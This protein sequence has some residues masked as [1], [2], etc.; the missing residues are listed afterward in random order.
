MN[1][2]EKKLKTTRERFLRYVAFDTTSDGGSRTVPSTPGQTAFGKELCREITE[3]GIEDVRMDEK[4]YIYGSL[5]AN[6]EK[7]VPVIGFLAHLDTASACR[8]IPC[9]PEVIEAYDGRPITLESG[10][11][12]DP[13]T[14]VNLQAAEGCAIAVTDG[15]SLLGGDDKAGIAEIV[16]ALAYLQENPDIPHGKIAFAFTPDEEI[17][18]SQ[19]HFDTEAFGADFAYTV[20][21]ADFGQ[22]QFENFYA[23]SAA[24]EIKGTDIHPGEAKGRLQNAISAAMEFDA[25]LP[26]AQRPEYTDGYEGFVHLMKIEG[27]VDR[28]QMTYIIRDHDLDKFSRKKMLFD[29]AAD[30]L[31]GKYSPETVA[32][33]IADSYRNM[34]EI[35]RPHMHL[36][37]FASEAIAENGGVPVCEAIRGGTDGAELSYKG[38]P[39]PNLGTGTFNHH[40]VQETANLTSMEKCTQTIL[41]II[42]KYAERGDTL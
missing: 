8:S 6:T 18:T 19:R 36:I 24:V 28:C 3:L 31:N 33:Q 1:E 37:K 42:R 30:Y 40:S 15:Y 25:M 14:D 27:T 41:S 23:A 35:V 11:V 2:V 16:T 34:A 13:A 12:L 10:V 4:G 9:M 17:G 5:P 39:C 21:G 20:D 38:I 7:K 26:Q 29:A 22:I 32:V